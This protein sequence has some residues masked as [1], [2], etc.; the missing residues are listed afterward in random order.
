M[1]G[2]RTQDVARKVHLSQGRILQ[3]RRELHESWLMHLGEWD[4]QG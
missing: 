3:M 2:E 1:A 4:G